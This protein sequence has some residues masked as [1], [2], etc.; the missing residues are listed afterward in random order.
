MF[1]LQKLA[2]IV[3]NEEE[4]DAYDDL[5]TMKID[6]KPCCLS[7][8]KYLKT[9]THSTGNTSSTSDGKYKLNIITGDRACHFEAKAGVTT[10]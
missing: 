6:V 4:K 2:Y 9:G 7:A 3:C 10:V 8:L 1:S 5:E